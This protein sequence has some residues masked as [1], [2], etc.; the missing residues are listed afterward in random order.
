[1]DSEQT[2]GTVSPSADADR[3]DFADLCRDLDGIVCD[4]P[5]CDPASVLQVTAWDLQI[6]V[7]DVGHSGRDDAPGLLLALHAASWYAVSGR[8]DDPEVVGAMIEAVQ[9]A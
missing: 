1:M 5:Y 7:E 3:I 6:R 8:I 4:Y 2:T 9:Q